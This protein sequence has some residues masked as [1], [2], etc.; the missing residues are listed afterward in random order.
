MGIENKLRQTK[1]GTSLYRT[2]GVRKFRDCRLLRPYPKL[3]WNARDLLPSIRTI[4]LSIIP[5][6]LLIQFLN[7]IQTLGM[8]L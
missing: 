3:E 4:F 1:T 2:L 7:I 8:F 5:S 6:I